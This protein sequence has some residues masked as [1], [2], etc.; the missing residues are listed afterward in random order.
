MPRDAGVRKDQAS[1]VCE[2]VCSRI[3]SPVWLCF[4]DEI[5]GKIFFLCLF[6]CCQSLLL[7]LVLGSFPVPKGLPVLK[8]TEPEYSPSQIITSE[9]LSSLLVF[10]KLYE[11]R[12]SR[13]LE[14][15][16]YVL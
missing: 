2:A 4:L 3:F 16:I 15:V 11:E 5:P 10:N 9:L 12:N 8:T 14:N 6:L 1:V 7:L 13:L